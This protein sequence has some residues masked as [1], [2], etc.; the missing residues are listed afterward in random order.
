MKVF[1]VNSL[2]GAIFCSLLVMGL[3][4]VLVI[5]PVACI[6]LSWNAVAGELALVPEIQPWQAALL[7]AA[8]VLVLYLSGIIQIEIKTESA[9]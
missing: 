6:N 1:P 8:F 5:L 9:D 2:T 3:I 4:G 7:Y